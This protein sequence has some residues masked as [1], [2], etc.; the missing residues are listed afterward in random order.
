MPLKKIWDH[1]IK[2]KEEFVPRKRKVYPLSKEEK[3]EIYE[4]IQ[5]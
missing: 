3:E 5:E 1:T 4:L 2:T